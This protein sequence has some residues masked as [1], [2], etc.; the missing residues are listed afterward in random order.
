MDLEHWYR[1]NICGHMYTPQQVHALVHLMASRAGESS[2]GA[3]ERV[4]R[5]E[6]Q[7]PIPCRIR[8]C[9]GTIAPTDAK[10]HGLR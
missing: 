8:G 7:G 2:A 1:C 6:P 10:Y 5:E 3:A 4:L 9:S